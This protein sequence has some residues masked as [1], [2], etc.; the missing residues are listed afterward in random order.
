M[1]HLP[2]VRKGHAS[3]AGTMEHPFNSV[4]SVPRM[5]SDVFEWF[6]RDL[7]DILLPSM[8]RFWKEEGLLSPKF[9]ISETRDAYNVTA[10]LPGLEEKDIE[11]TM[12]HD[13]LVLKGE[14]KQ[15]REQD[16]NNNFF[17]ESSYSQYY[18]EIP[19][20]W[21]VDCNK[22]KAAFRKGVLKV[23]L[24]KTE[25]SKIERRNVKIACE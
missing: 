3:M 6:S 22:V 4:P 19:M 16:K 7:G 13:T 2:S 20:P 12:D 10:E 1:K 14:K 15:E 8:G 25:K 11:L 21:G 9:D 23:T 18:R 17:S 5:M 24:P